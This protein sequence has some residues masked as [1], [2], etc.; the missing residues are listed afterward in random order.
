[1]SKPENLLARYRSYS[2][3]QILIVC[4]STETAQAL[5]NETD[6]TSFQRRTDLGQKKYDAV[7]L[8][9]GKYVV[10]IDGLTDT[11]FYIQSSQWNTVICPNKADQNAMMQLDG[12]LQIVE[13]YGA[14]FMNIISNVCDTLETDPTGLVFLLKTIFVGHNDDAHTYNVE[15][16][17][18]FRPLLFTLID[19]TAQFDE[20]G[21][22]YNLALVGAANG[23]GKLPHVSKV[24]RGFSM[25]IHTTD[26]LAQTLSD[27]EDRL[28]SSYEDFAEG[29]GL[30]FGQDGELTDYRRVEYRIVAPDYDNSKYHAGTNENVRIFDDTTTATYQ[31]GADLNIENIIDRI[32][33]SS[34]AVMEDST[35]KG[36]EGKFL[37]KINSFLRSKPKTVIVEYQVNRYQ[38]GIDPF[39][40]KKTT[41]AEDIDNDNLLE[42]DYMFTGLN[43]DILEMDMKMEMGLA[44]FH[45]T[46][47]SNNVPGQLD[48]LNGM[49]VNI[50]AG[51][52]GGQGKATSTFKHRKRT[53][54]FL[55]DQISSPLNRNTTA[56]VSSATFQALMSRHAALE[57]LG[58]V[59]KIH[60][61]P[62]LMGEMLKTHVIDDDDRFSFMSAPALVKVNIKMPSSGNLSDDFAEQFWYDGLYM[63]HSVKTMFDQ[64]EFTQE[65]TLFSL[66]ITDETNDKDDG[67]KQPYAS[68]DGQSKTPITSLEESSA[69]QQR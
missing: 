58:I 43:T 46:A 50:V 5:A 10:L 1:M 63:L 2:Y 26:N 14:R 18:N 12:D 39:D 11:D 65:L 42:F 41:K 54:L 62:A 17:S 30:T 52:H 60:G 37:Y 68:V 27:L 69:G 19:L 48:G 47:T 23:F 61:N 38:V 53:P 67:E 16:H 8:K 32:M 44:F 55:G 66:I 22:R 29:L 40:T 31:P 4:E 35:G 9:D 57:N 49:P 7:P 25:N 20:T 59:M 21:A 6:V 45:T 34:T 64:G 28:N 15:M 24:A 13:P 33:R 36:T 51:N 3:H 56:P